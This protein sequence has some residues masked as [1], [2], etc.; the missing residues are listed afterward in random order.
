MI[1]DVSGVPMGA[2]DPVP[3]ALTN[4]DAFGIHWATCPVCGLKIR[5][6]H[7]KDFESYSKRE[8]AEHYKET[9]R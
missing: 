6:R 7:K 9:H 1:P 8:Y 4:V 2:S 5:L 3:Y